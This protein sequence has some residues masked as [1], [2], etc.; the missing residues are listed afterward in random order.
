ME[1]EILQRLEAI[2]QRNK[3]VELDKAR[4]TS[5]Q[6]KIII[7]ILTYIVIVIFFY[8]AWLT[9]PFINAIVPTIWFLLSTIS[10][11]FFKKIWIKK[12][13]K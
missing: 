12:I 10:L 8:F 9:N 5:R 13:S 11:T 6:R 1:K 4:E 3:K 2:E 7:S